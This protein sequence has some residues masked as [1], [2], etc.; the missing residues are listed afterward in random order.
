MNTGEYIQIIILNLIAIAIE[1][2]ALEKD[3]LMRNFFIALSIIA[4]II[5]ILSI[6]LDCDV[7]V[8]LTEVFLVLI[9]LLIIAGI[10]YKLIK[11][12]KDH[13]KENR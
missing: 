3:T 11:K 2:Y 13:F 10:F 4:I 7:S 12:T 5:C 6:A 9:V 1:I 8:V